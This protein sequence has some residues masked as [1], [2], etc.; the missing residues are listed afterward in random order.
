MHTCS[1]AMCT[2]VYNCKHACR[3][4]AAPKPIAYGLNLWIKNPL[5]L[6]EVTILAAGGMFLS[7]LLFWDQTAN[8]CNVIQLRRIKVDVLIYTKRMW[9][10]HYI[11]GYLHCGVLS[12]LVQGSIK[13]STL[14]YPTH[15]Q[16]C[17]SSTEDGN[18]FKMHTQKDKQT[19]TCG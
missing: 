4:F 17:E 10:Y 14:W 8:K 5:E 3:Y 16:V 7:T 1:I 13:T 19:N 6:Q 15:T 11:V 2:W 12:K 18:E 9:L